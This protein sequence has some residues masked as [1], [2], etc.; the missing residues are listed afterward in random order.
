MLLVDQFDDEPLELRRILDSVLRLAEN[1][2]EGAVLLGE[3]DEDVVVRDLQ[4]G[5][6]GVEEVLPRVFLGDDSLWLEL[7]CRARGPSS[8]TAGTSAARC[9]R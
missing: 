3:T 9:T 5:A 2:A 1:R 4:V 7:P 6:V 8:G